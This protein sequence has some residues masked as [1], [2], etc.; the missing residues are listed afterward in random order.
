MTKKALAGLLLKLLLF[1]GSGVLAIVFWHHRVGFGV[2]LSFAG[3]VLIGVLIVRSFMQ[4]MHKVGFMFNS[5]EN[6]DFTFR[7]TAVSE[8]TAQ[9]KY[10]NDAL[11]RIK[12]LVLDAREEARKR[13]KY[14]EIILNQ[15]STGIII[16]NRQ[17]VVFQVNN[18]CLRLLGI[19]TLT[20]IR[21]LDGV[22]SAI[23]G[24][25]FEIGEGQTKIA[26]F[27][28]EV[29]QVTLSMTCTYVTTYQQEAKVV[30]ITDLAG[31]LDNTEMDSWQRL[32]RVLTHEI[33]NSLAPITSLSETLLE[34]DDVEMKHRGLLVINETAKGLTEFVENYR[35]LTKIPQP[36]MCLT[37]IER[38]VCKEVSLFDMPIEIILHTSACSIE[39]DKSLISQVLANLIKNALEA[40]HG[41]RVWIVL[42][43]KQTGE[44]YIDICNLGDKI[45]D[46]MRENIFVPFFTT[47]EKGS[48]VGL[49]L[50]RQIMRLH[51][52]T[53]TL[54]IKPH[55]TFRMQF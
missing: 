23:A 54:S 51:N 47:K 9:E 10:V 37:N 22:H 38:L 6:D 33:M 45:S 15:V 16:Y 7:F 19:S 39:V 30:T 12:D 4:T 27:Y 2:V 5:I 26:K 40:A 44:L 50:S 53:L 43:R 18:S 32:S 8:R 29:S 36:V 11:N 42:G 34:V 17:G 52:G 35:K 21:Q 41:E 28:D 13:E 49:S 31:E 25:L 14:F 55:T 46:E 48:G 20:H 24:D 3:A 1:L